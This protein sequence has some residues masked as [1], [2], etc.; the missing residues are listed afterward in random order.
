MIRSRQSRYFFNLDGPGKDDSYTDRVGTHLATD[1]V[2][3]AHAK[4][5]IRD[6]KE[7]GGYDDPAWYMLVKDQNGDI[8]F[9]IPF[10][11]PNLA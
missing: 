5:L 8:V 7:A 11:N 4:V 3:L 2:A 9:S 10:Q 6:L 1:D